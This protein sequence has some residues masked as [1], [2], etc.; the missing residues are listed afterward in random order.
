MLQ[1]S[2]LLL[3][4]DDV[5]VTARTA[6]ATALHGPAEQRAEQLLTAASILHREVG[7]DCTDALELVGLEDE[8]G[9]EAPAADR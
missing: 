3:H 2:S 1:M 6:L 8:C 7:L 4:S 9:C 5:P